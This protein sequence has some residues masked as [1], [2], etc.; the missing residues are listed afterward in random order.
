MDYDY[1]QT[2]DLNRILVCNKLAIYVAMFLTHK[3]MQLIQT[4]REGPVGI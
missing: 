2:C 3:E 1:R 4:D